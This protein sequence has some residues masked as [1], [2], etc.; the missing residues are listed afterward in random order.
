MMM[1]SDALSRF[2]DL[3]LLGK[4]KQLAPTEFSAFVEFDIVAR[5]GGTIPRRYREL[6]A[7]TVACTTQCPDCLDVHARAARRTG[8]TRQEVTEAV[9]PA[10]ALRVGAA[11]THGAQQ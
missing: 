3:K 6:I 9:L 2:E 1:R 8:V 11:V 7:I 4:F 10:A 5:D